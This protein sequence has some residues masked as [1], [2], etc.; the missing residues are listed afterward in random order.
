VVRLN[1]NLH[2]VLPCSVRD[3]SMHFKKVNAP[4]SEEQVASLREFQECGVLPGY[5]CQH[6]GSM[7]L[8]IK[9]GLSCPEHGVT[10]SWAVGFTTNGSWCDH[11][12]DMLELIEELEKDDL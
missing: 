6:C 1:D 7:L 5:T 8:P 9:I 2:K 11:A 4:F 10:Q 3:G 12:I